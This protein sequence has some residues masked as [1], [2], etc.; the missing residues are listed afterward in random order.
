MG[1][2]LSRGCPAGLWIFFNVSFLVRPGQPVSSPRPTSVRSRRA[3]KRLRM[4]RQRHSQGLVLDRFEVYRPEFLVGIDAEILSRNLRDRRAVAR[5]GGLTG[6]PDES[7]T[8]SREKGLSRSGNVRVRRG[9]IQLAWRFLRLHKESALPKWVEIRTKNAR[10]SR[11][12]M[13]LR[14]PA[15]CD[16]GS[17]RRNGLPGRTKKLREKRKWIVPSGHPLDKKHPIQGLSAEAD[18]HGLAS[19]T[20]H[21]R[22]PGPRKGMTAYAHGFTL[23]FAKTPSTNE[24]RT[25][26]F[27]PSSANRRDRLSARAPA[28]S[29]LSV[30][31]GQP[32]RLT[33]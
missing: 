11:K 4:A 16:R 30:N 18:D 28:S 33:T 26:D 27:A 24:A 8:R 20:M 2:I 32:T 1:P 13:I 10:T 31:I 12:K 3:Q 21:V 19:K 7:G 29:D 14:A 6:S 15:L 25:F 22:T 23:M 17:G 5:Y 9:M